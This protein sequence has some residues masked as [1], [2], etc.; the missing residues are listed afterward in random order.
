MNGESFPPREAIESFESEKRAK[1]V[2]SARNVLST[3]VGLKPEERVLFLIDND[4][5]NTDPELISA[6]RAALEQQGNQFTEL[7]GN[8]RLA[9]RKLFTAAAQHQF[10]WTSWGWEDTNLDFYEFAEHLAKINSRMAFSPGVK[11]DALDEGGALTEPKEDLDY[12]LAKMEQRLRD[13]RAMHIKTTYGT[14]LMIEFKHGERRWVK[15]NG[16]ILEPGDWDNLPGGEIFTTPDEKSVNGTLVLPVLQD[17][18]S[19]HQGVDE[20]VKVTIRNGRIAKIDGG[21]SAD[22]LRRYL[23]E[24]SKKEQDPESVLMVAEIAF[25]ANSKARPVVSNPEGSYIDATHP[26]TETEKRLGTMHLAF[27]SSKHGVEGSEGYN[28]SDV[29]L[30]FV[31]PRN[32]LTVTAFQYP[33]QKNGERLIDEG[34]WNFL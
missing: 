14:D 11:A 3:F 25:G 8:K 31:I 18:V 13:V 34:R 24:E 26:T 20:Y 22:D 10:I 7:V 6:F 9:N 29:H 21:K 30:D 23:E 5:D 28:E 2:E 1:R 15:D 4:P 32:G 33:N 16:S 27:G 12:R 19:L 17:E